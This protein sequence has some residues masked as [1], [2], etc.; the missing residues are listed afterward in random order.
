LPDESK[1]DYAYGVSE[2]NQKIFDEMMLPVLDLS[3]FGGFGTVFSYG[4][5]GSGKTYTIQGMITRIGD[6]LFDRQTDAHKNEEGVSCL[7]IKARFL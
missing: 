2:D 5:T 3:L 6:A 4:Q 7:T 1:V